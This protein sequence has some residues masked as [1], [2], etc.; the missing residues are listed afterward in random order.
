MATIGMMERKPEHRLKWLSLIS[1]V[2]HWCSFII[3]RGVSYSSV[4]YCLN[5]LGST[6]IVL[7][8]VKI[9][10]FQLAP[11]GPQ[12][13]HKRLTCCPWISAWP[14]LLPLVLLFCWLE[15]LCSLVSSDFCFLL[16]EQGSMVGEGS[17]LSALFAQVGGEEPGCIHDHVQS[18]AACMVGGTPRGQPESVQLMQHVCQKSVAPRG[19]Y[20]PH[21]RQE[22]GW[23]CCK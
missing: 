1:P 19:M 8:I 3:I 15:I 11:H 21:N 5:D 23:S 18:R 7:S 14:L 20:S 22:V 17:V 9:R 4:P 10:G 12:V 2:L 13:A 6:Y 16:Q